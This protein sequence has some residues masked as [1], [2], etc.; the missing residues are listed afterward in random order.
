MTNNNFGKPRLKIVDEIEGYPLVAINTMPLM[1]E[2]CPVN[3]NYADHDSGA[4]PV[5]NRAS[6]EQA[7]AATYVP[8]N[9]SPAETVQETAPVVRIRHTEPPVDACTFRTL[10]KECYEN[11]KTEDISVDL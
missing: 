7:L 1:I 8:G 11:Y 6:M 2:D 4:V 10:L 5:L 9:A 3:I